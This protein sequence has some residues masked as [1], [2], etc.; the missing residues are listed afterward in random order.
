MMKLIV[1]SIK[2]GQF[3]REQGDSIGRDKNVGVRSRAAL[4]AGE[5]NEALVSGLDM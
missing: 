3:Y 4:K 5:A 2:Y 1:R